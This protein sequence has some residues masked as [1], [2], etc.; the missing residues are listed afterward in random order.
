MAQQ[1]N[2][3]K[4]ANL[5][6]IFTGL[7]GVLVGAVAVYNGQF[8]ENDFTKVLFFIAVVGTMVGGVISSFIYYGDKK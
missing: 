7:M 6:V 3:S 8:G 1:D 2:S 5:A 4:S